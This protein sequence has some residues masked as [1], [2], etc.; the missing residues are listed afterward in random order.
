[1]AF[2]LRHKFPPGC[3]DR[4]SKFSNQSLLLSVVNHDQPDSEILKQQLKIQP[5]VTH[6]LDDRISKP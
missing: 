6:K 3:Y 1:M 2:L 4:V 5:D